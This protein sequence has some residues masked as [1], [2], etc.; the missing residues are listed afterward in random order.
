MSTPLRLRSERQKGLLWLQLEC[1]TA[2]YEY[3]LD[4]AIL[5]F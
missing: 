5:A 1:T 3:Y 4:K 2:V